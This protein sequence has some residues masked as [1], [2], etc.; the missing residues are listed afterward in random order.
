MKVK[1]CRFS[2]VRPQQSFANQQIILANNGINYRL[3]LINHIQV[4][5]C[6]FLKVVN[7]HFQTSF[8]HTVTSMKLLQKSSQNRSEYFAGCQPEK[9]TGL[10]I[11]SMS[12][13]Y[14]AGFTQ[15]TSITIPECVSRGQC[16]S[17]FHLLDCEQNIKT[18]LTKSD[19]PILHL[20]QN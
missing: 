1:S 4:S 20:K 13:Y 15:V 7:A 17:N 5:L 19:L 6:N 14:F 16:V 8:A 18:C 12:N 11:V 10:S 3:E 9:N 2:E